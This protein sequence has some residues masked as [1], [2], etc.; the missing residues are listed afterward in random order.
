MKTLQLLVLLFLV[1]ISVT[2][3]KVYDVKNEYTL[4]PYNI[5]E[6][7]ILIPKQYKLQNDGY[8]GEVQVTLR[9]NVRNASL[10]ILGLGA[11]LEEI[12]EAVATAVTA[13][14][15]S[16]GPHETL[17]DSSFPPDAT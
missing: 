16:E 15:L 5:L 6:K 13:A 3:S 12:A 7:F 4:S 9:H 11:S 8:F 1:A 10:W 2:S 17:S 14:S